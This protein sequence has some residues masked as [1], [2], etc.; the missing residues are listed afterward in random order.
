MDCVMGVEVSAHLFCRK[1]I[2]L[3]ILSGET[4]GIGGINELALS[5]LAVADPYVIRQGS[6]SIR[7]EKNGLLF[8][9]G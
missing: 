4:D 8:R 2:R 5:V 9:G 7:L 1:C 6:S 3:N